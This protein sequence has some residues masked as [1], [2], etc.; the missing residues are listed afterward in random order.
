MHGTSLHNAELILEQGYK[1][2]S[3][4]WTASNIEYCYA[5]DVESYRVKVPFYY[6]FRQCMLQGLSACM[7]SGVDLIPAVV[8]ID[9][10]NSTY[11]NDKTETFNELYCPIQIETPVT[12]SMIQGVFTCEKDLNNFKMLM[13]KSCVQ[14]KGLNIVLSDEEKE[15]ADCVETLKYVPDSIKRGVRTIVNNTDLPI[16][17]SVIL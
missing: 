2:S 4:N 3:T 12:P 13:V 1:P 6:G 17:Q 10:T 16:P 15:V 11:T 5:I 7:C 14:S 9:I 8:V